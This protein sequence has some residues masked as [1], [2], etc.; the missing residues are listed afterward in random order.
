V[1]QTAVPVTVALQN[2]LTTCV[3]LCFA[4]MPCALK[5]LIQSAPHTGADQSLVLQYGLLTD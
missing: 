5:I 3:D 4:S 1:H 2:F